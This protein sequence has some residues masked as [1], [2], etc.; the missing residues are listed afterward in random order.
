MLHTITISFPVY[1]C[2]YSDYAQLQC[3]NDQNYC[4]NANQKEM[5]NIRIYYCLRE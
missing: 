2:T 5:L 3:L 4:N 1:S